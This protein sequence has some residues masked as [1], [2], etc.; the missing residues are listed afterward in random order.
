MLILIGCHA[1]SWQPLTP[2]EK[3]YRSKCAS[4]HSLPSPADHS[5]SEWDGIVK[6]HAKRLK[7]NKDQ[8]EQITEYLTTAKNK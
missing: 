7:L 3:L 2:A 5:N 6:K 1:K 8:I 4:C